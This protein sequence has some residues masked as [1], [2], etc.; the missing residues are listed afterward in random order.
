MR[1][2]LRVVGV[3]ACAM[4]ALLLPACG[5]PPETNYVKA[6]IADAQRDSDVNA[7]WEYVLNTPEGRQK[8]DT[9]RTARLIGGGP[10]AL[11]VDAS[12]AND[13]KK[14]AANWLVHNDC[15]REKGYKNQ[16]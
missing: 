13:P 2:S 16:P 12:S 15:I 9:V 6:G 14:E 10:L 5:G 3:H 1:G 8:A 4:S 7:C 11:M